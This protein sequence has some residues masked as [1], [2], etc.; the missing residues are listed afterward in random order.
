MSDYMM[1]VGL[2][3]LDN[4]ACVKAFNGKIFTVTDSIICTE[5]VVNKS[6]CTVKQNIT[7][8]K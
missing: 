4:P 6:V 5:A 7:K 3:V 8:V 2:K 1:Y